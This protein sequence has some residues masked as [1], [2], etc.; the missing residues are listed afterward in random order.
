MYIVGAK[1]RERERE[2]QKARDDK[3]EPKVLIREMVET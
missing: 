1:E 3:K 2:S